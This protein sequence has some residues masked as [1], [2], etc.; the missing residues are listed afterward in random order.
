MGL[1][2]SKPIKKE[3]VTGTVVVN[4]IVDEKCIDN[5]EECRHNVTLIYNKGRNDKSNLGNKTIYNLYKSF[6]KPI[7]EHFQKFET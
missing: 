6:D 3:N 5:I 4:F 1:C 7:P 2:K